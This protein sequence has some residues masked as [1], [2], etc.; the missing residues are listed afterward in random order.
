VSGVLAGLG[1]RHAAIPVG[2]VGAAAI[3][4]SFSADAGLM[5]QAI[6]NALALGGIIILAW[7]ALALPA[8][9]GVGRE[10]AIAVAAVSLLFLVNLIGLILPRVGVFAQLD[11]NWQGKTLDLVWCLLLIA[12]SCWRF[13]IARSG[14]AGCSVGRGS[15]GA[16]C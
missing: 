3:L 4:I 1:W 13:S 8:A 6:G 9:I 15:A 11:W 16:L 10:G 7:L 14:R 5:A 12:M 2:A